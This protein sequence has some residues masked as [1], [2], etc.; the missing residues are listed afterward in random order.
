MCLYTVFSVTTS[1]LT[2]QHQY[3]LIY[4]TFGEVQNTPIKMGTWGP[5]KLYAADH[6]WAGR[7]KMAFRLKC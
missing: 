3:K 6:Q 1:F 2:K 5:S 4:S 7:Q